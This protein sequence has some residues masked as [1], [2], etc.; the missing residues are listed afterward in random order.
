M[1]TLR[2]PALRE[3]TPSVVVVGAGPTGLLLASEL[4]RRD[5]DCLLIDAHDAPLGWDRATIVHARSIEIFEALGLAEQLIDRAVKIRAAQMRSDGVILGEMDLGLADGRYG[6]DLGL[7][8][9]VTESVLTGYLKSLGGTVTRSTRLI[10]FVDRPDGVVATIEQNGERYEVTTSWLVGCD[11]LHSTT[12]RLAG[13][14][15]PGTDLETPWAVFDATVENWD[16]D[17]DLCFAHFDIPAL[18]LTPLPGRRWRVYVRP[19]SDDSDL[20]ADATAT[21]QRYA[22]S[23]SS[24]ASRMPIAFAVTPASP[25]GSDPVECS[26]LAMPLTR[27]P[28]RR[29]TV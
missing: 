2:Q 16:Q 29:G 19:T 20:V 6:F 10:G 28:R 18:I 3:A 15:Y 8:E 17:F 21:L 22:P 25:T 23:A 24:R 4:A 1:T 12:R 13:I 14:G 26:W 5:V 9:D 27:A 7:S 11:G